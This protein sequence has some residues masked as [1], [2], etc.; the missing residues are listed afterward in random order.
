MES[1]IS[2][3]RETDPPK[4]PIKGDRLPCRSGADHDDWDT[5]AS[6]HISFVEDPQALQGQQRVD[7]IYKR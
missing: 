5:L 6:C 3:E 7:M 1:T 2:T 4:S